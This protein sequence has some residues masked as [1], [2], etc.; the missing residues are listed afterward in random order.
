MRNRIHANYLF[1]GCHGIYHNPVYTG[2]K[3]LVHTGT[4]VEEHI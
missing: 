4:A 2:G 1:P 3:R